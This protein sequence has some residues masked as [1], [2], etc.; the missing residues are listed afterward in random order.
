MSASRIASVGAVLGGLV[1]IVAA[2][3]DWGGAA[4]RSLAYLAGM[5]ILGV[6]MAAAGYALVATAPV[7]L[8]MV[9]MFATPALGYMVWI[10]VEQA[11]DGR[12]YLAVVGAGALMVLAGGIGL[13]QTH[14]EKPEPVVRGRRAAR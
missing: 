9:V 5:A 7:W 4:D 14:V 10:T 13:T 6:A 11:L 3:K 1:W 8:R 12:D 2:V